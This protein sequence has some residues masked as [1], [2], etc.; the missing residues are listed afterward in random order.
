MKKS[1]PYI[2]LLL[3]I[4]FAGCQKKKYPEASEA[5]EGIF[6]AK[7]LVNGTPVEI[8]TDK[9]NY[10][11]YASYSMDSSNVYNLMGQF[12]QA[13]CTDCRKSLSIQINDGRTSS[14]N[15]PVLIDSVLR[16]KVYKFLSGMLGV[17]Y[18]VNFAGTFNKP[19]SSVLWNFGDG[20]SS[21][22]L[23]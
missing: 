2:L 8:D 4:G 10:Y 19:V 3:I 14:L 22:Q 13:N 23:N 12:K 20:S 18:S 1:I 5:N 11:M 9:D 6:Y 21:T 16:P 17:G 7:L 15:S